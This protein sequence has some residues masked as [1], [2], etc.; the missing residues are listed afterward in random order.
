M[1]E[2]VIE[3]DGDLFGF[4][5]DLR[6]YIEE[7]VKMSLD[8]FDYENVEDLVAVLKDLKELEDED[9]MLVISENNGMGISVRVYE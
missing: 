2:N 8:N 7:L 4:V 5:G 6:K 3:K 9:K 1:K